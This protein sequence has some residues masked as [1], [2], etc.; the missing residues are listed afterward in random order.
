[1]YN[2]ESTV[3]ERIKEKFYIVYRNALLINIAAS[4]LLIFYLDMD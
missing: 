4:I 2:D 1:M 3:E